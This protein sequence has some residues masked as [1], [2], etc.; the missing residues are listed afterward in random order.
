[1]GCG[2]HMRRGRGARRIEIAPMVK[3]RSASGCAGAER[4]KGEV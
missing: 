4:A 1:M 2:G 3:Y